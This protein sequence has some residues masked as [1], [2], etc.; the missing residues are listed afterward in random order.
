M[1]ITSPTKND[2]KAI[3][4]LVYVRE[5]RVAFL[6][7]CCKFYIQGHYQW[8]NLCFSPSKVL[9]LHKIHQFHHGSAAFF[10]DDAVV[11]DLLGLKLRLRLLLFD[12][13]LVVLFFVFIDFGLVDDMSE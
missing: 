4:F 2:A 5:K 13:T 1:T 3:C 6:C 8:Y 9:S 10:F 11:E 7:V 12:D